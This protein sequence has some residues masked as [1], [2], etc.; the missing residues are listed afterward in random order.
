[1]GNLLSCT[2]FNEAVLAQAVGVVRNEREQGI[3][4]VGRGFKLRYCRLD[5]LCCAGR[6]KACT[7]T[8]DLQWALS[9]RSGDVR[10]SSR[11]MWT[12][13][14][15]GVSETSRERILSNGAT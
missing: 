5:T 7:M 13:M 2:E 14:K 12:W 4:V 6:G 3:G 9:A 11:T 10:F 8:L 15:Y 1:M